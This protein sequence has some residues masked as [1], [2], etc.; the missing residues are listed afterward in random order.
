MEKKNDLEYVLS[1]YK[2]GERKLMHIDNLKKYW[3]EHPPDFVEPR[4]K[5]RGTQTELYIDETVKQSKTIKPKVGK[6]PK[7][8]FF[9]EEEEEEDRQAKK[10]KN[11]PITMV[12][13]Y[14]RTRKGRYT[15]P[16]RKYGFND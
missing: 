10:K 9:D 5:L 13:Y 14:N 1:P 15:K 11:E 4:R 6:F 7:E 3:G 12:E 2:D 8:I 16:P